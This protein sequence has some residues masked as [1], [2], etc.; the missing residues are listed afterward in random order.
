MRQWAAKDGV[1]KFNLIGHSQGGPTIRYTAA[2][3]P[4]L[5]ASVTTSDDR[6]VG[7]SLSIVRSAA[8]GDK[9]VGGGKAVTVSDVSLTGTDADNY[10][11]AS[12]GSTTANITQRALTVAYVG[13][14]R[15]YDGGIVATVLTDD[16]RVNGDVLTIIRS[17]AF[18]DKNVGNDKAVSVSGV[19]LSGTDAGNYVVAATG[20]TTANI[21]LTGAAGRARASGASTISR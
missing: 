3:A 18:A 4:Q 15:V 11:V 7:D 2:V 9:N 6:V 8:F 21:T 10:T 1:K 12:T 19:S 16:N 5:V 20:S 14:N 17:A 13:V